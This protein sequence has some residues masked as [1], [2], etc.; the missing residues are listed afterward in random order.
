[1]RVNGE[2]VDMNYPKLMPEDTEAIISPM[3][4]ERQKEILKRDGEA[5]FSF[6]IFKS[7]SIV[8]IPMHSPNQY[9]LLRMLSS[10]FH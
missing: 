3:L 10:S 2:L 4:S 1:M 8:I 6:S 9:H 5:D 7:S